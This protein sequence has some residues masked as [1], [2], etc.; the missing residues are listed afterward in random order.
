[1][2]DRT[3]TLLTELKSRRKA[4][5]RKKN[6]GGR[7]KGDKQKAPQVQV[8]DTTKPDKPINKHEPLASKMVGQGKGPKPGVPDFKKP[9]RPQYLE[10][11][12]QK[13]YD[14]LNKVIPGVAKLSAAIKGERERRIEKGKEGKDP[15]TA[16]ER[17]LAGRGETVV[18]RTSRALRSLRSP[19]KALEKPS[20]RV[21]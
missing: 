16:Y 7:R 5:R 20:G 2:Y 15:R 8:G 19:E 12:S 17:G 6:R 10:R 1:M 21:Y 4:N 13:F 9:K 18:G 14:R 11:P 3:L